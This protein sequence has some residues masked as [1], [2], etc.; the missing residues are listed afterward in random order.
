M[1]PWGCQVVFVTCCLLF[2]RE[3]GR[4]LA[5]GR[6]GRQGVPLV[7]AGSGEIRRTDAD[8][9][10]VLLP[11]ALPGR[12]PWGALDYASCGAAAGH[13]AL[14]HPRSQAAAGSEDAGP[15]ISIR[16]VAHSLRT[17]SKV[18]RGSRRPDR[19]VG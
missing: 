4:W 12:S 19:L 18:L 2:L 7:A 17:A 1:K 15:D 3:Q 5:G 9:C 16:R 8:A 13:A 14:L 10:P 11:A 6:G